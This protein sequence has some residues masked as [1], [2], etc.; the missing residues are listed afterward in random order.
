MASPTLLTHNNRLISIS[1]GGL[2]LSGQYLHGGRRDDL[3]SLYRFEDDEDR[4]QNKETAWER[5]QRKDGLDA[6]FAK[7]LSVSTRP[8]PN[9]YC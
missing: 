2:A 7:P 4:D 6:P 1:S 3:H 5:E 8:Y 9:V